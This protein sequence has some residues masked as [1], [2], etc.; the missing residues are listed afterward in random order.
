MSLVVFTAIAGIILAGSDLHPFIM[1]VTVLSIAMGSGAAGAINMWYD[2]D[3][4]SV[5]QRTQKRPIPKGKIRK[6]E[7]LAF[8]VIMSIISVI[9]L[10]AATNIT[11]AALLAAAILF[12]VFV[13]TILLKRR[14]PQNIV[15]GGAAGSFPPMIGWAAVTGDV[16]IAAIIL[17]LIIFL[18]TPPHF[19]ALAIYR[20]DD[21]KKAKIPMLPVTHGINNTKAQILIYTI[22]L[23]AATYL[24][25]LY[26]AELDLIYLIAASI[27]NLR[28]LSLA[29]KLYYNCTEK[30][31]IQM[32]I[33]SIFYL[34]LLF[35][36][37]IIDKLL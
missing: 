26:I 33:Y 28:F 21:Y 32:F 25:F 37:L 36:F 19:W 35:G 5:M 6:D 11:A 30:N 10:H 2:A 14:T 31:S 34:F 15:I 12:Y 1:L 7:V 23:I 24:P 9:L 18:W 27:I 20:N 8:G 3:I 4:D 29:I 22:I 17:F 13:Y 16:S